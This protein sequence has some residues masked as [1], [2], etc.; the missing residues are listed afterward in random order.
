MRIDAIYSTAE[1]KRSNTISGSNIEGFAVKCDRN[2][3]Y[4][5]LD[6]LENIGRK[7]TSHLEGKQWI[8][9]NIRKFEGVLAV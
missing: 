4:I 5:E 1:S 3:A 8:S 2:C 9:G 7:A 6:D